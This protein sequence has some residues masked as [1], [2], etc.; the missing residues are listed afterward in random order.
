M[1][2]EH[3]DD[4]SDRKLLDDVREHGWHLVGIGDDPAG[5]A[6]VFSVGMYHTLGHP[7]V[8]IV[9]LGNIETMGQILNAIG[10]AV[11][12]GESYKDWSES[13]DILEGYSC[14]FRSVAP[15]FYP[16]YFG[17]GMWFYEGPEFPILQCV[18][19]DRAHHF[20]W[21]DD[22]DERLSDVQP[23]WAIDDDW[24]FAD[25][26]NLGV[27]TTQPVLNGHPILL[28]SHDPDGDWQ[29]LCGTTNDVDDGRL[30]ALAEIVKIEPAL[31]ELARLPIGWRAH[32]E[33]PG[34]PWQREE[35]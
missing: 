15:T 12:S 24:P 6:Y 23:I 13:S 32:R 21:D 28:V 1:V 11:R 33:S 22:V 19:P 30:V 7:E 2:R 9:G 26:K 14:T 35:A 31:L 3:A 29:F 34:Q 18:W 16:D 27:L 20:P 10:E 8:C 17:Y 25:A 5:P 4:D